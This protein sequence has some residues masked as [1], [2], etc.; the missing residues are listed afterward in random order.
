M[1]ISVDI[2]KIFVKDMVKFYYIFMVIKINKGF[3]IIEMEIVL[4]VN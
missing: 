2:F 1:S 4:D 3:I